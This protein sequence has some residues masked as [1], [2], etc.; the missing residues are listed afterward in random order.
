MLIDY[1]IEIY[2][3]ALSLFVSFDGDVVSLLFYGITTIGSKYYTYFWLG[4]FYG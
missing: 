1:S 2:S 4:G 3:F